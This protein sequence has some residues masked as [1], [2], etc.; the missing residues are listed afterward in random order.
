MMYLLRYYNNDAFDVK[1]T[2]YTVNANSDDAS[3]KYMLITYS[4]CN[5]MIM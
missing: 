1:Y 4:T 5:I 3:L 2:F